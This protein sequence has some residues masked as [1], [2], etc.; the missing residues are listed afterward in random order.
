MGYGQLYLLREID[1][2]LVSKKKLIQ[3]TKQVLDWVMQFTSNTATQGKKQVELG[4]KEAELS[5]FRIPFQSIC[6][7]HM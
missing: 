6:I 4:C 5:A 7:N 2:S 3:K 1:G